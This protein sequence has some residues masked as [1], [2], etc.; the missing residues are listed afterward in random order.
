MNILDSNGQPAKREQPL[1]NVV[2]MPEPELERTGR[3]KAC[4]DRRAIEL[5]FETKLDGDRVSLLLA[6][7]YVAAENAERDVMRLGDKAV[8][9]IL[10][11][12]KQGPAGANG[13]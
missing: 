12:F 7:I 4:G 10:E 11:K 9:Q 2:P 5:L 8:H 3:I 6:R 13:V 1:E